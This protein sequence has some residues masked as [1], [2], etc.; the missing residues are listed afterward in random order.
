MKYGWNSRARSAADR[1]IFERNSSRALTASSAGRDDGAEVGDALAPVDSVATSLGDA[2]GEGCIVG[3]AIASDG[4]AEATDAV[5]AVVAIRNAG[6]AGKVAVFGTDL[7]AQLLGFLE[8]EDGILQA[9]TAQAPVEM[10][11]KAI[12]A[13][14]ALV[15]G[16][17]V[18]PSD[19]LP[20]K[21]Y[22]RED[23]AA[24]AAAHAAL[25]TA[26]P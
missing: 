13:A 25:A 1:S 23:E 7:S 17:A 4:E 26:A 3:L 11:G 20:G 16:R 18:P 19:T 2:E 21:L 8:A 6:A 10:G 12:E 15:S 14:V 9:E 5:G 22:A 24:L